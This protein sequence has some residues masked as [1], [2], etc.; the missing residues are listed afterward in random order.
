MRR[1]LIG[2]FS[3][4]ALAA[5]YPSWA[6]DIPPSPYDGVQLKTYL[7]WENSLVLNAS[8]VEA[9]IVPA[10]GGRITQYSLNGENVIF[11]S[12]GSAGKTL[13]YTKTNFW[14]GGYQCDIGPEIRGIPDHK[15]LWM[16][17]WRG[18]ATKDYMVSVMSEPDATVG[19]QMEKEILIEP[20]TGDLGITQRM[21]NISDKETGFCLWDRTLCKGGGFALLPLNKRSRFKAG[22]SIRRTIDEKY[23]YDG[24]KPHS[25]RVKILNDVLVART[26]GEATK[27]GADSD[28]GW[29]AYVRG[30]LLFVKYFPYFAN[31]NYSDGGNS[32]EL[33]FDQQVS[34]LEP[35]S[36]EIELKPGESY[37]F[38]EKWTLVE[39]EK[40][41]STFEEARKLVKKVPPSPFNRSPAGNHEPRPKNAK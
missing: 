40:E 31:R 2:L 21:K 12:P 26:G 41:V 22:W 34:E 8:G 29:I 32:V 30:K 16:G 20:G 3:L 17:L 19:L 6:A 36:P 14:V 33:Y 39:L 1:I 18:Q 27:V 23:V 24:N 37:A 38:P 9:I 11:E 7:G 15:N 5:I 28:A 25:P 13:A 4:W 10:I 35:L